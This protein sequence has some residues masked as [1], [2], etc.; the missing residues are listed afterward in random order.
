ML[1]NSAGLYI[2]KHDT[3]NVWY[4]FI[5]VWDQTDKWAFVPVGSHITVIPQVYTGNELQQFTA[6]NNLHLEMYEML[7]SILSAHIHRNSPFVHHLA[8]RIPDIW[9]WSARC[10]KTIRL[11]LHRRFTPRGRDVI[12]HLFR[13]LTGQLSRGNAAISLSAISWSSLGRM[14]FFLRALIRNLSSA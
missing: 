11:S 13:I 12:T 5:Y 2:N 14:V 3:D 9:L 6:R 1:W 10:R 8:L 7:M 4:S